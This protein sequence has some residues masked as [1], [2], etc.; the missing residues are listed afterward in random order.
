[1]ELQWGNVNNIQCNNQGVVLLRSFYII[2][3]QFSHITFPNVDNIT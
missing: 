3:S 2:Q 1:M